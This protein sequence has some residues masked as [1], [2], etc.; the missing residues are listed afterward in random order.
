MADVASVEAARK[1]VSRAYIKWLKDKFNRKM[2]ELGR[3]M[4][5]SQMP[6][7]IPETGT[8][9]DGNKPPAWIVHFSYRDASWIADAPTTRFSGTLN[10]QAQTD[11]QGIY[12]RII[13]LIAGNAGWQPHPFWEWTMAFVFPG[14][15]TAWAGGS[16]GTVLDLD[17]RTGALTAFIGGVNRRQD[18]VD[19][20]LFRLVE[21][22]N[23]RW[24]DGVDLSYGE[25][26]DAL[27]RFINVECME[28]ALIEEP[29]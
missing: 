14:L 11:F 15:P 1:R 23:E 16:T 24:G 10:M 19:A 3:D 22:P 13:P 17:P 25:A 2:S 29:A 6:A 9:R 4:K 21:N 27:S 12:F 18:Y 28:P 26:T 5:R 7:I 20:G 8:W